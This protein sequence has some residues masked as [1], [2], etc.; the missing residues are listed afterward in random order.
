[1]GDNMKRY[2][3][4]KLVYWKNK[5]N[6]KPLILKGARQ[7]GKT[8]LMKEFGKKCFKN[9]A[10][11]NFDSDVRVR[12]IFE[13]D[14]DIQRIIRMINI[15]TGERIIPEE[16]LIIFDEVQEA[17]KAISSLKYFCENAPEYAVVS[18]GSLLGVAIHEGVSFPVGKVESLNMYPMSFRE[19]LTAMGEEAL[20]DII[21]EKDYQALNTFSDKYIN[22]LKLYYFVGGMPEAVND[23]AECGDV[24]SVRDIQK[25]ILELYE[26]DFSKH[27][28]NDELARIRMVWNSIPLQLAKENKKF[29][30]GQIRKGA[31]AKDFE[32]AIEWL[33]DCGLAGK[34]YRVEKPGIP[35]KAYTDFSA[36]KIYLLDVGLLGAMSDLDARSILEKNELFTEFKGALTEQYVYQQIISETEYTPYYFS[37]S[38]HTEIDF[39]IQKEGQVIPLEVKAEE[40]VKA[41]SL[42]AYFNKYNPPYAVRTSMMDYRK[43]EWMVNIPLYAISS[44]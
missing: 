12:R 10:Y 30:F 9:T 25:Q 42:K 19:F 18:A 15:E 21:E 36:F 44:L 34:V 39:L 13:E 4:D 38:S 5:R 23:Y 11:I 16:T 8:W 22:W 14:Y 24:T 2:A 37:A 28:P 1:M 33:Q 3:M 41:K 20:A 6:R 32:L 17:P 35:L 40:N 26:N 27:T 7:V 31:R 43:E 29:F